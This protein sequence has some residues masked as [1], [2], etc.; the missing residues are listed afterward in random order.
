MPDGFVGQSLLLQ[1]P[2]GKGKTLASLCGP[3][4]ALYV[5]VEQKRRHQAVGGRK[6][7]CS[8]S[9]TSANTLQVVFFGVPL[10]AIRTHNYLPKLKDLQAA[11]GTWYGRIVLVET[12]KGSN[13]P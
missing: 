11:A 12:V 9:H 6:K 13:K 3:L 5:A 1:A 10:E 7:R 8:A 2:T 4:V